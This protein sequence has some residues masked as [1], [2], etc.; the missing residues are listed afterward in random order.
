MIPVTREWPKT[1]FDLWQEVEDG[2]EHYP[3]D[4]KVVPEDL[5]RELFTTGRDVS[6]WSF[7][8]AKNARTEWERA[9]RRHRAALSR[10]EEEC[11]G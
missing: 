4:R 8:T 5:A 6:K 9:T 10:Y 1:A 2:D 3:D 7:S 11:G